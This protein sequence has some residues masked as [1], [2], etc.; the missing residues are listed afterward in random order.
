[1]VAPFELNASSLSGPGAGNPSWL[2]IVL[3]LIIF[4]LGSIFNQPMVMLFDDCHNPWML[5]SA[6]AYKVP[7][8]PVF[9]VVTAS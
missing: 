5:Q 1:M 4:F 6:S 2:V 9:I 3:A 8:L 7:G